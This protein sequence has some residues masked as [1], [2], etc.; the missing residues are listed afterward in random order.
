MMSNGNG[1]LGGLLNPFVAEQLRDAALSL[2]TLPR[3]LT[4]TLQ[5]MDAER[6]Q[7]QIRPRRS[8]K[9]QTGWKNLGG[10]WCPAYWRPVR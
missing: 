8:N 5:K 7:S 4:S 2:I 6:V 9:Q 3:T 10:D 1:N